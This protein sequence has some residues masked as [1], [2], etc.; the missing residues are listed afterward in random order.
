[1]TRDAL[2]S[3]GVDPAHFF[4]GGGPVTVDVS[5]RDS[6]KMSGGGPLFT[7]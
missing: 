7:R 1:M 5:G 2:G 6:F 3:R 4:Y